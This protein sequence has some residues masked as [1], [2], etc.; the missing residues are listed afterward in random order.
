MRTKYYASA[1]EYCPHLDMNISYS[2]IADHFSW[3][4]T[5]P[6]VC[7]LGPE[8]RPIKMTFGDDSDI[9]WEEW[10]LWLKLSEDNGFPIKWSPG[11]AVI[12]DNYR[13][14]HGRPGFEVKEGEKR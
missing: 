5:W 2:N 6:G 4:D 13:F 10:N 11:D 3:F 8:D 7:E 1:F 12:V 14:A 9:T